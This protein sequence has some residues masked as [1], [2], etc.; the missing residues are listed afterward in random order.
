MD[1]AYPG[2]GIISNKIEEVE[3]CL[4]KTG[5]SGSPNLKQTNGSAVSAADWGSIRPSQH[6]SVFRQRVL[7]VYPDVDLHAK[8][9]RGDIIIMPFVKLMH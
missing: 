1:R 5:Y 2:H 8:E 6:V 3:P 4:I 7:F 9:R